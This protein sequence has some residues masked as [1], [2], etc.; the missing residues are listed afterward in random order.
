MTRA[1]RPPQ[2]DG[3]VRHEDIFQFDGMRA[4]TAHAEGAPVVHYRDALG[5]KGTGKCSTSSINGAL[6]TRMSPT[7]D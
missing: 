5:L 6:V 2:S 7:A 1:A 4:G 3:C